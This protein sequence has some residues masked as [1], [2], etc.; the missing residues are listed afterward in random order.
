MSPFSSDPRRTDAIRAGEPSSLTNQ[1]AP[2]AKPG[3]DF[4]SLQ[5][6]VP[7]SNLGNLAQSAREKPLRVARGWLIFVG[8]MTILFNLFFLI[9]LPNEVKSELDKQRQQA[10]ARQMVLTNPSELETLIYVAGGVIYGGAVFLGVTFI[11]LACLMLRFPLV[12][13]IAS[14]ALYLLAQVGFAL[15]EP[16]S[17]LSGFLIKIIVIIV[18][19]NAIKAAVAY[20]RHQRQT[21]QF[22]PEY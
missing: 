2:S 8:I 20:E 3:N 22:Q 4:A 11:V 5:P 12:T 6:G 17:L 1:P 21:A 14:M 18:L 9:N 13:T 7:L 19:V 15:L 16:L 10:A